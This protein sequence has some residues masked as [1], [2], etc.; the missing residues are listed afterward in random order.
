MYI[1]RKYTPNY[2]ILAFLFDDS[3]QIAILLGLLTDICHVYLP[4]S[5]S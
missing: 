1:L 4:I 3:L 5:P 2:N